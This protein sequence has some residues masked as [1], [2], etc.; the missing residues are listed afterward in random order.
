MTTIRARLANVFAGHRMDA[1]LDRHNVDDDRRL[2]DA[3][4]R[5]IRVAG[6]LGCGG[7]A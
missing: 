4:E 1:M 2:S 7:G 6:Q 3:A 5:R